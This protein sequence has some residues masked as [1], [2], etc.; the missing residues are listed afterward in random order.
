MRFIYPPNVRNDKAVTNY[1]TRYD[2]WENKIEDI[3][4]ANVCNGKIS[5][6]PM[7]AKGRATTYHITG[8]EGKKI[9]TMP[10]CVL[11]IIIK[12]QYVQWENFYHAYVHN[13]NISTMPM[14]AMG[15]T[16]GRRNVRTDW[17]RLFD[18]SWGRENS[19][20]VVTK[21]TCKYK[22]LEN[23]CKYKYL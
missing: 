10:M 7:C 1:I 18:E 23:C 13:G 4:H 17:T 12:C 8:Y 19:G 20:T 6:M 16:V 22:Y 2:E 21:Y 9:S 14:C 15:R 3:Y 11:R 5:T